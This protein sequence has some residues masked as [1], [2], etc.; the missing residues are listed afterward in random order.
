MTSA[1]EGRVGSWQFQ[2]AAPDWRVVG[3]SG[4]GTWF[5]APDHSAGAL[6]VARLQELTGDAPADGKTPSIDLRATGI[7]VWIPYRGGWTT[8]DLDLAQ[9][10]STAAGELRLAAD[11]SV[12]QELEWGIDTLDEATLTAF[13][14]PLLGYEDTEDDDL[15]DP[16]R[17]DPR[18]WFY[19][20]EPR[21][22]RNR[23]HFD[24]S[25]PRD[26]A[27]ERAIELVPV[28]DPA[29]VF[30]PG[31]SLV[32]DP[33]GNEVDLVPGDAPEWPGTDD[34]RLVF[35]GQVFYPT[36]SSAE[37]SALVSQVA[38]LADRA[39]MALLI[40]IRADGVMID[41]GK[42]RWEDERFPDLA[43]QIQ[44]AARELGLVA[45]PSRTRFFQVCVDAVDVPRVREFWRVLLGY[46]NDPRHGVTDIVDPRW[47]NHPLIFQPMDP[48]EVDRCRQRNRIHLDLYVPHDQWE[49]RRAAVLAAGGRFTRDDEGTIADPEGN[50]I[51][52]AV[53]IAGPPPADT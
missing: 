18:V 17:R 51:D 15:L 4:V 50:E 14:Q 41:T 12:L 30:A 46:E 29:T 16:L 8:A 11:P 24:L 39:G 35:A 48:A 23:I 6:L 53:G 10:V 1:D 38:G 28:A 2:A 42:D 9:R 36:A 22:L 27:V 20:A 47:L 33:E 43:R 25:V 37:S 3:L 19:E 5:G 26:Q 34:W 21:P 31:W 32:A 7:Q 44:A 45:D 13:W 52:I 49:A 40:D